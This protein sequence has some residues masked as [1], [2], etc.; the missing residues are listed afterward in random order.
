MIKQTKLTT[1]ATPK[2]VYEDG[3]SDTHLQARQGK[4]TDL[5]GTPVKSNRSSRD[6]LKTTGNHNSLISTDDTAMNEVSV[7]HVELGHRKGD[8]K[9]N[10]QDNPTREKGLP[11]EFHKYLSPKIQETSSPITTCNGTVPSLLL[12]SPHPARNLREQYI[13]RRQT[14]HS[15]KTKGPDF[16]SHCTAIET[17]RPINTIDLTNTS[18]STPVQCMIS[19]D[20][21]STIRIRKTPN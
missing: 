14:N 20:W 11:L 7:G 16:E 21:Q 6:S 10:V 19:N 4:R 9:I 8:S 3:H 5:E 1:M 15:Y 2:R 12:A 17:V 18:I 13:T